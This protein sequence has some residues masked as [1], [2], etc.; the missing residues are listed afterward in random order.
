MTNVGTEIAKELKKTGRGRYERM[1]SEA[2]GIHDQMNCMW[3]FMQGY[4]SVNED[5]DSSSVEQD[6][7]KLCVTDYKTRVYQKINTYINGSAQ[8]QIYSIE[9]CAKKWKMSIVDLFRISEYVYAYCP[10]YSGSKEDYKRMFNLG[11]QTADFGSTPMAVLEMGKLKKVNELKAQIEEI[12]ASLG[13]A[14]EIKLK[15]MEN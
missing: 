12:C 5:S 3:H 11:V 1:K 15:D 9:D 6:D 8:W 2:G 4:L 13:K 7:G 10:S 14:V